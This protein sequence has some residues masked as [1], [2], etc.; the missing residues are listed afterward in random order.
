MVAAEAAAAGTPVSSSDRCGIA[1]LLRGRRGA[2][3]AVRAA[4]GVDAVRS[5]LADDGSARPARARRVAAA[6]RTS[7]DRV[8]DVQ[9]AIYREVASRTA[10]TKRLHR[11]LVA[12]AAHELARPL[13]HARGAG[14]R[15]RRASAAPR[16]RRHVVRRNEEAVLA[17]AQQVVRGADAVREDERQARRRGLVDDDAPRSRGARAARRRPRRRTAARA[18]SSVRSP[19]TVSRRRARGERAAARA[20]GRRPRA[21]ARAAHRRRRT[22]RTS[23][24]SPFSGTRRPT[25]STTTSVVGARRHVQPLARSVQRARRRSCSRRRGPARAARRARR[26]TSRAS[27]PD[28]ELRCAAWRDQ[29]G[30]T[31][32]LTARR[33]PARGPRSWL[34]TSSTYGTRC[35]PAPGDRR[36]RRRTCS[37]RRRRRRPAGRRGARRG[38]RA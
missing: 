21:R 31:A 35:V 23:T 37:S 30:T 27:A 6:R 9:E 25:E 20:P 22:A 4:G 11:R 7:W 24:S 38:S 29:R 18:R 3:R 26:P 34:S 10:A 19:R 8:A 1:R 32:P 12:P 14:R 2:G 16:P 15:P 5:V 13:A 33:Q 17:V 28:H 36:L